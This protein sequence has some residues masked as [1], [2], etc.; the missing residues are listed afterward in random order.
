MLFHKK[1]DRMVIEEDES[2]EEDS[3]MNA[4]RLL[5]FGLR[6]GSFMGEILGE[7]HKNIF[8][9]DEDEEEEE[10]DD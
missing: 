5:D 3:V 8:D 6:A 2:V 1:K 9:P 4:L 7:V 10:D